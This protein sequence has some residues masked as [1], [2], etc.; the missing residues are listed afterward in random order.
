[1]SPSDV[2][3]RPSAADAARRAARWSPRSSS[4]TRIVR[5]SVRRRDLPTVVA[6]LRA[7]GAARAPRAAPRR[8]R[9][10]PGRGRR[11][12]PA[13]APRRL[14]LPD[15]IARGPGHARPARE[16]TC[17]L[18]LAARPDADVR[19]A[20]LGRARRAPAAADA[21]ASTTRGWPS[22]DDRDAA[23]PRPRG[24]H[25]AGGG[26]AR[27]APARTR[28]R[29][30]E[31]L[32][33]STVDALLDEL[34][35]PAARAAARWPRS[36]RLARRARAGGV[37][38]RRR[39]ARPMRRGGRSAAGAHDAA[40]RR[41]ARGG[42][43]RERP[44]QGAAAGARA[45]RRPGDAVLARHRRARRARRP[46]ARG[47]RARAARLAR[48]TPT[49]RRPG[50]PRRARPRMPV[51]PTSSCTGACTGTRREFAARALA[52]AQPGTGRR[53]G[54]CGP[55]T[56]SPRC[57]STTR[58]TAS[59]GCATRPTS[60]PGGT[61]TR[62][63]VRAQ[64]LLGA[65]IAR[66]PGARA[67]ADGERDRARRARRRA[68][69]APRPGG[70]AASVGRCG[71]PRALANPLMRGHAPADHR[72]GL[73]RRRPARP[74]G[75]ARRAFLR[76]RALAEP[77]AAPARSRRARPLAVARAEH[78]LRLLGA[79]CWRSSRP[80]ARLRLTAIGR[81]GDR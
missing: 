71:G 15:A 20:R 72:R 22:S 39:G 59:P 44:A 36:S 35:A 68:R 7:P 37:R 65:T 62:D 61:R 28:P 9:A 76:R 53:R 74:A 31:L 51:C 75:P 43:D 80:R 5:W 6:A 69:R 16:S 50:A 57:C 63:P 49:R 56:S 66:A 29:C 30:G 77:A 42:R 55:R 40:G 32:D 33:G 24:A 1:M 17:A 8:R 70:A 64:P 54:A 78:V 10:P 67:R 81:H 12:R 73:P 60:P 21:R 52:R 47:R 14:A 3:R 26:H 18:V 27:P 79:V 46:R 23:A 13:S 4:P 25:P 2:A 19:G 45:A 11:A 41:R 38:R 34:A 58:A 48:W